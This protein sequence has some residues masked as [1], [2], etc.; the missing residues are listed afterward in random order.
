EVVSGM[1]LDRFIQERIT[2]PLGM[3]STGFT[4]AASEKDR[5]AQPQPDASGQP[6]ALFDPLRKPARMSGGGGAVSTVADYLRF[7]QMLLN[8]GQWDNVRVLAPSTV[9]LMTANALRPG[10][11]YSVSALRSVDSSPTPALGQGFGLGFSVRLETGQNPLPG[12]P[13]SYFWNGAYGTGFYIDP[14]EKLIIIMMIQT[15]SGS[16]PSYRRAVRYLTYQALIP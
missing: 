13:G 4:V 10:I 14:R 12:S 15:P 7:C 2:G 5:I 8:G 6:V 16:S 11:G 1:T 9:A 3:T